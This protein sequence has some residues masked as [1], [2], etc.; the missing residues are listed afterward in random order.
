MSRAATLVGGRRY[1][2]RRNAGTH[3]SGVI[4]L[5]DLF[6]ILLFFILMASSV[7][8]VSG[9][10]VDLPRAR[11]VPQTSSLG[12]AIVTIAPPAEPGGPCRI[13]YRDR[14][15][16]GNDLRNELLSVPPTEKLLIIRADKSVPSGWLSEIMAIAEE[17]EME[18]F[19]AVD[20]P[21]NGQEMRF[22]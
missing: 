8:R 22:E 7:V 17:A 13:Y 15:L 21:E 18:T 3:L 14:E 2:P 12:R 6:F 19:I 16:S 20:A 4:A 10:K 11:G 9:I 1:R 5:V